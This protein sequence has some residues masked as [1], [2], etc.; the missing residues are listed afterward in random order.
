MMIEMTHARA[1]QYL[2]EHGFLMGTGDKWQRLNDN[3]LLPAMDMRVF[4]Q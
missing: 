3:P 1:S 4:R 2:P